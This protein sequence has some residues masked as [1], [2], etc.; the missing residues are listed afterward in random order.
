MLVRWIAERYEPL[1]TAQ[2]P[3]TY[4]QAGKAHVEEEDNTMWCGDPGNQREN[5]K[6]K[7]VDSVNAKEYPNTSYK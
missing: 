3:Y 6:I 7:A 4:D 2:E 1:S 5:Q